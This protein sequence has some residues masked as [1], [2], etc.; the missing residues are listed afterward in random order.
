MT[1]FYL[2]ATAITVFA[3]ISVL[4]IPGIKVNQSVLYFACSFKATVSTVSRIFFKTMGRYS[5][6]R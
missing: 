1:V 3:A 2:A 6:D 5:T 4:V